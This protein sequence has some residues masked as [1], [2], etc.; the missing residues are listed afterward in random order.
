MYEAEVNNRVESLETLSA[1]IRARFAEFRERIVARTLLPW[2]EHCTECV[3]PTCYTSCELYSPRMDGSC[4]QF[5]DG[6]VRIDNPDGLSPYVL[7]IQFKQWAKFWTVG[8]LHLWP[9]SNAVR[10]E[11]FNIAVGAIGRSLPLPGSIKPRVMRKISYLR[12]RSAEDALPTSEAPDCFLLECFNP[13]AGPVTLTFTIRLREKIGARPF[14]ELISL[15]PGYTRAKVPFAEI[16]RTIDTAQP[17]EVEIVPNDC[18][19]KVL[20]FGLMDFVLERQEARRE[21]APIDGNKKLKCVVWDLDN[22]LWDGILVEDGPENIR[23]RQ[24]VVDTIKQLDQRGILQSVASKNNHDD[25]MKVLRLTGLDEY[26]LY[27]QISWGPKSQSVFQIAQSL[28]IGADSLALVDDQEFEREEVKAALPQV[29]VIDAADAALLPGRPDCQ[30]PVT[31]ESKNRRLMYREQEQRETALRSFDGNYLGFLKDCHLEARIS[32][33]Q[34]SNLKRVYEL[35]QRTNQLNFSGNRYLESQLLEILGTSFLETYVIE[36][37]DRFGNYGVVGF[38]IVDER[39]PR[40]QDLMFSCR[41]QGKRVE[42]AILS[43][44]LKRFVE[45]SNRDF[46]ANYRQTPKNSPSGKVFKEMGFELVADLDGVQSLVFRR[47]REFPDDRI[48]KITTT[49][50]S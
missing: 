34:D 43:F 47:G 32:S 18:D 27:P 10:R 40:L 35:A 7:K 15:P 39:E 46:Y 48:I 1:D 13:N 23:T 3:W 17:F 12:R 38:A 19:G 24:A 2:G 14:Q 8:N 25:A 16:A 20:F 36:C 28:N 29:T 31:A 33:L 11:Q 22:T 37:L 30:V 4:R 42:H 5:T 26:F 41:V 44:L 6:M 45:G 9:L 21:S 50:A 49:L